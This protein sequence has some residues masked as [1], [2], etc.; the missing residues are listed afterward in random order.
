MQNIEHILD[1][2]RTEVEERRAYLD[3]NLTLASLADRCR[4]NRTYA[5]KALKE[6]GGFFV[7]ITHCR[8][9]YAETWHKNHPDATVDQMAHASGFGTRQSYYNAIKHL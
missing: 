6:F 3:P 2:I 5:S 1:T 4:T 9:A 8:L 7:Y